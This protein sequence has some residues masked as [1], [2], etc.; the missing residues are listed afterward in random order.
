MKKKKMKKAIKMML[1][2]AESFGFERGLAAQVLR[3]M[4]LQNEGMDRK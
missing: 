2:L 3:E 4:L 1:D